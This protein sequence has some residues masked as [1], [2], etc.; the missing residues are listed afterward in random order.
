[1]I[2][3]RPENRAAADE[4]DVRR[5]DL[6]ELL[7]RM[8]ASA[9]RGNGGGGAFHQLEQSLLHTFTRH[10]ACNRRIFCLARNFVDLVDIDD[11]ALGPFDVVIRRLQQL[12]NDILDIFADIAGFGQR[13]R[14]SHRERN[15]EDTRQ[16]LR[17]QRL[18]ATRRPDEQNV[19]L[20][21]FD[22]GTLGAVVEPLIVIM[23]RNR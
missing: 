9:L 17:Q 12:Q 23:H 20:S 18:A 2:F 14:I 5:V 6:Q 19:R 7:L 21:E 3:S 8:L 13:C 1:M 11:A 16:R 22:I 15:V 10:V 4:Q